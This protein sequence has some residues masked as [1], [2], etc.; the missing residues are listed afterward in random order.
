MLA[1]N[2]AFTDIGD[3]LG[4]ENIELPPGKIYGNNTEMVICTMGHF[5]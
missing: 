3:A 1:H 5:V 4:A 2:V